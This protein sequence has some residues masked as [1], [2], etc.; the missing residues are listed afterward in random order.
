MPDLLEK[1]TGQTRFVPPERM[2]DA[3]ASGLFEAPS[4]DQTVS[5]TLPGPL[6]LAGEVPASDL[7]R[8]AQQGGTHVEAEGD[9][10]ARERQTRI[11]RQHGG[12]GGKIA[13][14]VEN[15]I[16]TA[17]LGAG[18]IVLDH[19]GGEEY[20]EDRL[21][22]TE[23]N[24][25]SATAGTLAAILATLPAGGEG[26]A[27]ELAGS[28]PLGA[29]SRLGADV[30]RVGEDA[31][32]FTRG[33]RVLAGGAIE[34]AG[35]GFGQAVQELN[36]SDDPLT[37]ERVTG[38]LSSNVLFGAGVG[39]G[40]SGA[41]HALEGGLRKGGRMLSEYAEG[42]GR[43]ASGEIPADLAAMSTK[44]LKAARTAEEQAIE[45]A[46]VPQRKQLADDLGAFRQEVRDQKVWL[47]T[48]DAEDPA[49]RV[50]G[51]QTLKADRQLDNLLDNPK[52]LASKPE[53]ALAALQ[54]QE[55][56][57][58]ELSKKADELKASF[59]PRAIAKRDLLAGKVPGELGPFNEQGFEQATNRTMLARHGAL[60]VTEPTT[61]HLALDNAMAALD[62]N[63]ALQQRIAELTA[64]AASGR[65]AAIDDARDALMSGAGKGKTLADR[66]IEGGAY[67]AVA[68]AVSALPIPGAAAIAPFL[69][70]RAAEFVS[71]K[72][73]AKI[74]EVAS[75]SAARV[76]KAMNAFA[77]V[78]GKSTPSATVLATKVLS[79]VSFGDKKIANDE[80]TP[81]KGTPKK[82]ELAQ[83]Y[84]QRSDEV[85][86]Q[87][88]YG[89][90]GVAIMRPDA[91][92]K[93]AAKLAPIR[94]LDPVA[95]DR[96]ESAA[97]KRLA[98][99]AQKLPRRP[100]LGGIQAGPN[101]WQP[102]DMEMRSWA[103]TVAAGEDPD[104]I[105]ERL[106]DGTVTPEDADVMRALYPEK[107][108]EITQGV[109]AKLPELQETLPYHRRLALSILTGVPVDPS[110]NPRVLMRLQASFKAE[111]GTNGGMQAPRPQ[112]AFGSVKAREATPA[113]MRA[114]EDQEP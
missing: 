98:Y 47:A 104:A 67:T 24:P 36:N 100:D 74:S 29:F 33:G 19:L 91:R 15:A 41:G 20:R 17:T 109:L 75:K 35:Q 92:A 23:A 16:D 108:A 10:R 46:R 7:A 94:A 38:A 59:E 51:K 22:R 101:L 49:I 111:P 88:S 99:Y 12:V 112:A 73:G 21:E 30:A 83:L 64:P 8:S 60:E 72:L 62:K 58:E 65:L 14:G 89:P 97:A 54:K 68:G 107:L 18:G 9:R 56:A 105:A 5:V 96:L 27:A 3:I 80:A 90:D 31:S 77:D 86:S 102:S 69:G 82:E 32:I 81:K 28:T 114:Q 63:R 85:K 110:M 40:F 43:V 66:V 57:L 79:K 50:I 113:Q 84:K 11:E 13:T 71:G 95:A 6:G 70:A 48:K 37:Y 76:A 42:A 34:G 2:A 26:F 25:G 103:R 45:A 61:R 52:Y 93:M 4:G 106:V 44:E 55:H 78:V 39:A 1:A 53:T 87:T